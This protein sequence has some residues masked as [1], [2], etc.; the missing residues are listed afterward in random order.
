M[1]ELIIASDARGLATADA[2]S[3]RTPQRF[4]RRARRGDAASPARLEADGSARVVALRGAGESFCSGGD[5]E[6]MRR[7]SL[8]PE[9]DNYADAL[10]LAELM[11][12]LDSLSKPTIAFIDGATFGGGV[13]LVACCDIAIATERARFSLSEAR[14][15]LIPATIAPFVTRAIGPREARR[16]MLT[17]EVIDAN[18]AKRI[19]LVHEVAATQDAETVF[20]R[21][22][23]ICCDARRAPE[24]RSNPFRAVRKI[25]PAIK[26]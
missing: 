9:Q 19:G 16:L 13:G 5:I 21:S 10:A 20:E 14:I 17:G 18:S 22:L 4:R 12:R 6:W 11:H 24:R 8:A 7:L 15:G 3:P 25:M 26:I 23:D 2:Q 1:S